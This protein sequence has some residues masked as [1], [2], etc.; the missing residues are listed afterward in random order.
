[1]ASTPKCFYRGN[2]PV[3]GSPVVLTVPTGKRWVVTSLVVAGSALTNTVVYLSLSGT[4]LLNNMPIAKNDT[5][6]VECM[7]VLDEG[8]TM[9]LYG[10]GTAPLHVSGIEQDVYE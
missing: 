3:V 8:E 2:L 4:A 6:A 7:Q 5:I 9:T 1:M 10:G